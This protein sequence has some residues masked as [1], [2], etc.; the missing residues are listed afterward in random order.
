M[1][2]PP[3]DLSD[4]GWEVLENGFLSLYVKLSFLDYKMICLQGG[5]KATSFVGFDQEALLP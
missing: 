1:A 4:S 5:N 3:A 2:A